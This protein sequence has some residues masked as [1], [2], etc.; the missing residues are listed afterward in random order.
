MCTIIIICKG[1]GEGLE[2]WGEGG[3]GVWGGGEGWGEDF[4]STNS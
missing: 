4:L 2:G 1:G 3:G